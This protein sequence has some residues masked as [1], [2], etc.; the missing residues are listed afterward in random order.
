MWGDK[1]VFKT[2]ELKPL[3]RPYMSGLLFVLKLKTSVIYSHVLH[4]ICSLQSRSSCPE[5]AVN[6]SVKKKKIRSIPKLCS[7]PL[8]LQNVN[9]P[10][11][12]GLWLR[13]LPSKPTWNENIVYEQS[14]GRE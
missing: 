3:S 6:K 5:R 1:W 10:G 4:L 7:S 8:S 13:M 9:E 14:H 11:T 2:I 12:W